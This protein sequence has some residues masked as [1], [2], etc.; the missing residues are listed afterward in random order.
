SRIAWGEAE[1]E[2]EQPVA[3]ILS[4]IADYEGYAGFMP[5][6]RRSKV[7]AK[8]GS[9]ARVYIEVSAAAGALTFWGQLDLTERG[10]ETSEMRVVEARLLEGNIDAFRAE[11]RL[12]P[13]AGGEHTKVAF[14]IFVDPDLPLPSSLISRENERAARRSI[15]ALRSRLE[16]KLP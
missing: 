11:W 3:E 2:L 10:E 16:G 12:A 7:L 15:E 9:R 8:R 4:V 5:N 14:R 13:S 6:F 1:A